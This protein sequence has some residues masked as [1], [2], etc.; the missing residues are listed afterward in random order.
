MCPALVRSS[1]ADRT[2]EANDGLHGTCSGRLALLLRLRRPWTRSTQTKVPSPPWQ[3][4]APLVRAMSDHPHVVVVSTKGAVA[5]ETTRICG[6]ALAD[7]ESF[8]AL[9][10][11]RMAVLARPRQDPK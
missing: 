6:K 9:P 10:G 4:V 2:R 11:V 5:A 7:M 8:W 1:R 3:L